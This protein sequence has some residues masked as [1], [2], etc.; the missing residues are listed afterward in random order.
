MG[1]I[2]L[3]FFGSNSTNNI[4]AAHEVPEWLYLNP[5]AGTV[6]L[7]HHVRLP[8]PRYCLTGH[9]NMTRKE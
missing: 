9:D 5:G 2:A 3:K 4:L 1:S 6:L 7:D 8:C